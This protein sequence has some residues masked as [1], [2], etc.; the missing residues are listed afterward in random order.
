MKTYSLDYIS[1]ARSAGNHIR[2]IY[3]VPLAHEESNNAQVVVHASERNI[4]DFML[5]ANTVCPKAPSM[6]SLHY[7]PRK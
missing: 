1:H 5:P 2:T 6:P 4:M 3:Y 7:E